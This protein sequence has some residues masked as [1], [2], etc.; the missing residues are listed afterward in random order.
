MG[1]IQLKNYKKY[2]DTTS[3]NTIKYRVDASLHVGWPTNGRSGLDGQWEGVV[4]APRQDGASFRSDPAPGH[5]S[6]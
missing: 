4:W 6:V 2:C 1:L 3:L 5:V